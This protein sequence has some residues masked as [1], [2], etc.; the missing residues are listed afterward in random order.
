MSLSDRI[1]RSI[2]EMDRPS[3]FQTYRNTLKSS[4]KL[5]RG[6]WASLCKLVKTNKLYNILRMDLSKKEADVLGSAMKRGTLK[7]IND[8]IEVVLRKNDNN[9]PILLRYIVEK[10]MALSTD[11][12]QKYLHSKLVEDV[13]LRHL[14]LLHAVHESYPHWIDARIIEFCSSKDHPICKDILSTRMDVVE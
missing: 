6:E 3:D 2:K 13:G 4:T 11:L 8:V 5:P 9:S 14:Q 7:H 10:K 12:I 1:I